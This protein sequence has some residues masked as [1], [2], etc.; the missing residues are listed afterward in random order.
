MCGY[1]IEEMLMPGFHISKTWAIAEEKDLLLEEAKKKDLK[2]IIVKFKRKDGTIGNQELFLKPRV[3]EKG[4]FIGYDGFA[5]DVTER[6]ETLN[7]EIEARRRAEF[8]V[9]LMSHDINN[10]NQGLMMLLEYIVDD[11]EVQQ[12]FREPLKLA[13]EQV[14]YATE[15]IKNVKKL[16]SVLENPVNLEKQDPFAALKTAADAASRSFSHKKLD[17]DV[18]FREN[19]Y[20]VL[21]D[22]FLK[23]LFFNIIHNSLKHNQEDIVKIDVSAKP[24]EL[25]EL[26][27]IHIMDNGPGIPDEEKKRILQRRLGA[28]GS[29]IGL[30]IVNYLLDRYEG[31]VQVKD[32]VEGDQTRGSKFI[33][34][35]RRGNCS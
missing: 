17:L 18:G 28:K 34:V 3:D 32:R 26:I 24:S 2:G 22:N 16:Q 7:A 10:I 15:L 20:S 27:E 21:A 4:E 9:D 29:G 33:I 13:V 31:Y 19:E 23:D 25:G 8:L 12:K 30:T 35:L 1:T 5:K 14:N 11:A 6:L